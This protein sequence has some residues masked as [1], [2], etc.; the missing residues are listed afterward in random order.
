MNKKSIVY[1]Y[2]YSGVYL[3][4]VQHDEESKIEEA[5]KEETALHNA[6]SK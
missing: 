4:G 1:L 3:D 2:E 5:D 6:V